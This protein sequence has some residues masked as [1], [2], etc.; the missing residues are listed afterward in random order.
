MPATKRAREAESSTPG[1]HWQLQ[2]AKARFSE[3]FRL[4]RLKGP[5][6]ITRG[7][8]E[9]VVVL[10][11]EEFERLSSRRNQSA[12]LVQFFAQSPLASAGIDLTRQP[13]Y[14]RSVEL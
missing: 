3:V 12:D 8:K 5:Q 1:K 6:W 2:T 9:A 10:P 7:G 14:G 4:A 11:A 13:D